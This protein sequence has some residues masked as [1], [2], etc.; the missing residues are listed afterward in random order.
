MLGQ[1]CQ[2]LTRKPSMWQIVKYLIVHV[3]LFY[4]LLC[5]DG[6][7]LLSVGPIDCFG[8]YST[9]LQIIEMKIVFPRF[10]HQY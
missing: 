6:Y 2:T 8:L 10:S 7:G 4:H 1:R 9:L 5:I 3:F